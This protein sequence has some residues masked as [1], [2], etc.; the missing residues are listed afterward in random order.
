MKNK[1][2]S[3]NISKRFSQMM[4]GAY[5]NKNNIQLIEDIQNV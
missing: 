4:V 3:W 1:H 5:R 2:F